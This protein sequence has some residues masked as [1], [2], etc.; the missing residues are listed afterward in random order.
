LSLNVEPLTVIVASNEPAAILTR[1][2]PW[3][4]EVLLLMVV[5]VIFVIAG[6]AVDESA[7][8]LP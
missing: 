2:A 7:R 5:F 4:G 8:I 3:V 6:P 1:P